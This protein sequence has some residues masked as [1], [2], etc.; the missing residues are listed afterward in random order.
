MTLPG[1]TA[2][3]SLHSSNQYKESWNVEHPFVT[4]QPASGCIYENWC[5]LGCPGGR[6]KDDV[7]GCC[8]KHDGCYDD[9]GYL[10]CSCDIEL[11][12]CVCP[13]QNPFTRKG[14]AAIAVCSYFGDVIATNRCNPIC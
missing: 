6:V 14:R 13:K 5:G 8:K 12:A 11:L 7:D 4:I 3:L 9:R 1:F 2:E 10:C